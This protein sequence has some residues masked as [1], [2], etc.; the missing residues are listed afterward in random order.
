MAPGVLARSSQSRP[1]T[2]DR[3]RSAAP[4]HR[5]RGLRWH[6]RF[7]QDRDAGGPII[8]AVPRRSPLARLLPL[9]LVGVLGCPEGPPVHSA[10]DLHPPED[11]G[12]EPEAPAA[13]PAP[14]SALVVHMHEQLASVSR[15]QQA[16]IRGDV[17]S[18]RRAGVELSALLDED[19]PAAWQPSLDSMRGEL[20]ALEHADDLRAVGNAVA[21][22]GASCGHCHRDQ[23][24]TPALPPLDPPEPA[25][26]FEAA[27][28][29]HRWAVDRMW[30]GLVGPSGDR[31]IRGSTMF[32]VL[33]G[34][35]ETTAPEDEARRALCERTQSLARRGHVA[36]SLEARST[37]YG[38]LLTTC[39]ECHALG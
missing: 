1:S 23:G 21:R 12:A 5:S 27:M 25:A 33:P 30:E 39:A 16:A 20:E 15:I 17:E 26:D 36:R 11:P 24:V 19:Q 14:P 22:L 18:A 34:C 37:I 32:V 8:L 4:R 9:A 29:D 2:R 31:W 35:D 7:S 28:R 10:I 6:A 3:W 13:E 38:R